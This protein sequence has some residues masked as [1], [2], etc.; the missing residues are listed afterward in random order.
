MSEADV[1]DIDAANRGIYQWHLQKEIRHEG[2]RQS[3]IANLLIIITKTAPRSGL[4]TASGICDA[5]T[6]THRCTHW[7]NTRIINAFDQ[8]IIIMKATFIP[9]FRKIGTLAAALKK[10]LKGLMIAAVAVVNLALAGSAYA[11]VFD[12]TSD[13]CTGGCGTAPFGTVTL[14]QNGTTVDVTVDLAAGN[15][16]AKTGAADEQAF[17]FNG[18]GVVLGDISVNQTFAGQ[19]LAA[20]TGTFNGDG[21]GDFTFGIACTTCGN[22]SLF[23]LASDIVF[24]VANATIAEL[25][26]ANNLGNIFVADVFSSATGNTGPVDVTGGGPPT[27]VP[28]PETYAMLLA[29]LG[30]MGFVARRRRRNA[31]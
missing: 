7:P 1:A 26:V 6:D 29:G 24:H 22:G 14:L 13:H 30:L 11:I 31:M 12:L 25:T 28:E 19:T 8:E 18:V 21:T 2:I 10:N 23:P 3:G 20:Q 4:A 5:S 9:A 27:S 15:S 17:K 16:W